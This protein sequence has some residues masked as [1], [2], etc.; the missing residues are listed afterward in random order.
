MEIDNQEFRD[1][2]LLVLGGTS[3][4]LDLVRLARTMGAYVIVT[5]EADVSQRIS[6][7]IA[8]EAAMVSTDDIPGLIQLVKDKKID[9]AFCGPSEFNLKNLI[10]LCDQSG[11]PC[12]ASPKQW[13][14]CSNK[15]IFKEYCIKNKVPTAQEYSIDRFTRDGQDHGVEYPLIVKPV[16]GCSSKG[17]SICNN[18][19]EVTRAYEAALA[20]SVS[21][22]AVIEQYIDNGGEIFSFR[23][24]LDEGAY[25]PY[26]TFDTYIADPV[27][28]K[29]LISAFTCFPSKH[30][31]AFLH[32]L[33][34]NVRNMFEDM[35]LKNGV[36]FIQSIP[37]KG[38]IYCHEMGY[39]LSG[40]MIYKITEPLMGINDMK[41][42]LR[43]AL[44]GTMV[45]PE[46]IKKI[47]LDYEDIVMAQLMIPLDSG[48]IGSIEGLD[49]IMKM[50]CI[51]D[52]LQYYKSGDTIGPEVMGTLGQHFGRFTL[53]AFNR[54]D[55]KTAVQMI[56]SKLLVRNTLGQDMYSMKFD[57][58]RCGW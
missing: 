11:L 56:Q 58:G 47:R 2:R 49:E 14:L 20:A 54:E 5:D 21:R 4:S 24:I 9:G 19:E 17:I 33:D 16:D 13:E 38:K 3:A 26:L 40:G 43:Y 23:Y 46:E 57:M 52:F 44:G 28:K 50:E 15:K 36:A 10:E 8:D 51:V 35:G 41:M 39:R 45:R 1:K 18:R 22:H 32:D 7:Q 37:Y 6:K 30:T 31:E 12:Y 27:N 53:K 48:T 34:P 55:M 25:D 29:Y 42:M